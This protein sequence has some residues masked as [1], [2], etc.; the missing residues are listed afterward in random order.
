MRDTNETKEFIGKKLMSIIDINT[1]I[2]VLKIMN[3]ITGETYNDSVEDAKILLFEDNTALIFIDYDCD[4]YRS[5]D[6]FLKQLKEMLDKN[7]T[8]GI[9]NINSIVRS[10]EFKEDVVLPADIN[11]DKDNDVAIITTDEYIIIMG[12]DNVS[13]YYP[14]N[15]FSV[16]ECKDFALKQINIKED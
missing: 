6:W 13:D 5:G 15:F 10:I 4:G 14:N 8:N 2:D 1:D 11:S 12:Q 9:K 3:E 16:K 7:L